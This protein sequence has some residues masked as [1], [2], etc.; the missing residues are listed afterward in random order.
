MSAVPKPEG[1]IILEEYLE[2][3][4]VTNE[5]RIHRTPLP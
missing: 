1:W 3:E 4:R 5:H 2:G